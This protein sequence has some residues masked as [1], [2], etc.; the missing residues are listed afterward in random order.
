MT[1]MG[2]SPR[3]IATVMRCV[4][5]ISFSFLFNGG[6]VDV[7]RP[8]RGLRQGDPISPYLFLLASEGLTCL[9]KAQGAV[10]GIEVA[11]NAPIVN[12]LLFVDDSLLFFEA[13]DESATRVRDILTTYCNASGQRIN[14]DKSSIFFSK[15]VPVMTKESIKQTLNVHNESL[16]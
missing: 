7:F 11:P 15:G 5:S 1:K 6:S 4:S 16:S 3:F 8:S 13:S 10:C 14:R 12:H 2:F 9:L